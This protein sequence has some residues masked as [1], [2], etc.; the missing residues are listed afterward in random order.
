MSDLS[1]L[2]TLERTSPTC[3]DE[4]KRWHTQRAGALLGLRGGREGGDGDG[5]PQRDEGKRAKS[6]ESLREGGPPGRE[7]AP[8]WKGRG[9]AR[10]ASA[11]NARWH[12]ALARKHTHRRLP[13]VLVV[14]RVGVLFRRQSPVVAP[15]HTCRPNRTSPPRRHRAGA[16]GG[17]FISRNRTVVWRT[18]RTS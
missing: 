4:V 6:H 2:G 14:G 7:A 10:A 1:P 8:P 11:A 5:G 15:P 16:A 12:N 13:V 9:D 3:S 18:P 17:H